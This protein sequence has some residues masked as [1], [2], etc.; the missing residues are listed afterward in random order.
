MPNNL[1]EQVNMLKQQMEALSSEYHSNNFVGSQDFNKSSRFNTSVRL[2]IYATA[3]STC[4][5]GEVYVNTGDG[6]LYVCSA[7][8]TW[9]AQT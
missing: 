6:K 8:D 1:Q 3:P 9:T 7:T 5:V 2:P 4:V